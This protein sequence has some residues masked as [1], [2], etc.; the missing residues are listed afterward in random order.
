M[1]DG[2]FRRVLPRFTGT[3]VRL[4]TKLGLT[5]NVI[6]VAGLALACGASLLA[7]RGNSLLA[8]IL[9]WVSRLLDGTD[10]I[11]ARAIGR[12]SDFGAYLDIVCDMA[13][14][15]IMLLGLMWAFPDLS[16]EWSLTLALYIMCI[17][18]ALALGSLEQKRQLAT[19]DNRGLRLAAGIAEGGETGLAYTIFLLFPSELPLLVRVWI[20]VLVVTVVARTLLARRVL[21]PKMP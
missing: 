16:R 13:A 21:S 3:L 4:Y 1:I 20:F 9:W 5:P 12:T 19:Q 8:I 15:T 6:S 10:G 14:N 18:S 11:Y 7:A 2:P 17:T